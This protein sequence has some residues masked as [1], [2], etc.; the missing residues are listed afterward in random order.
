MLK[1]ACTPVPATVSVA[2]VPSLAVTATTPV[3]A[4]LA[5]GAYCTP[6]LMLWDG[7]R[8]TGALNPLTD[9]PVPLAVTCVTVSL[10]F[11]VFETCTV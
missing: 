8:V 3:V 4:P 11:P 9:I 10:E 6:K 2:T 1:P 7:A 5:V